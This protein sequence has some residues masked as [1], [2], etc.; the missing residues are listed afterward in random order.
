MVSPSRATPSVRLPS[1]PGLPMSR[2]RSGRDD[3]NPLILSL[4]KWPSGTVDLYGHFM[5]TDADAAGIAKLNA[6][7]LG[8]RPGGARATKL[9]ATK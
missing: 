4:K 3:F 8:G 7:R 6:V 9:R 1:G 5:G 2:S